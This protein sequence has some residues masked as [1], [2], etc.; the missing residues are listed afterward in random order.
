M[1]H[2][3]VYFGV[4]ARGEPIR[5][6]L[7]AAGVEFENR[8]LTFDEFKADK[9]E[10]Y[11][12]GLP[13][14]I[15]PSGDSVS[16]SVAIL[17]YVGKLG[18]LYPTD[19]VEALKVDEVMD[20]VQDI[21]TKC[22]HDADEEKKKSLREVYAAGQMKVFFNALDCRFAAN[23]GPFFSGDKL[24]IADL[25]TYYMFK[26]IRV[27]MFDYVD[28]SYVDQW[29]NLAGFEKAVAEHPVVMAWKA[30]AST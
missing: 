15:L 23:A 10:K 6:A 1:T 30:K 8:V 17:R 19:P 26:M 11:P 20:F 3:I 5:I 24:S 28:S 25:F 7:H 27:G 22:P 4:E 16:Q 9:E 29:P 13:V 12:T 2:V 14:L 18:D 21:Y